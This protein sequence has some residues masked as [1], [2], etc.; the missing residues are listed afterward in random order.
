MA[1]NIL[2]SPDAVRMSVFVVSAFVKMRELL[3][4]TKELA[5]Q[6][7]WAVRQH[8]PTVGGA[9]LLRGHSTDIQQQLV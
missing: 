2:N 7:E 6:L 8:R 1:A 3:G 4:G 5:R 9:A